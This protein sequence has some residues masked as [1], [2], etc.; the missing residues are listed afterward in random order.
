MNQCQ[1][2][3]CPKWTGAG[4]I[5]VVL[6]EDPTAMSEWREPPDDEESLLDF[7]LRVDA[8]REEG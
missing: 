4:C 7:S 6:G 8:M 2:E 3:L 5:C 1:Q